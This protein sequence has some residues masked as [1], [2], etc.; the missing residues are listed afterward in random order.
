MSGA[1]TMGPLIFNTNNG[2][3]MAA[4]M[5]ALAAAQVSAGGGATVPVVPAGGVTAASTAGMQ[6]LP[7]VGCDT[8][9][10]ISPV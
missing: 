5:S 1:H 4:G 10:G 3:A 7:V 2:A 6:P 9:A 8:P